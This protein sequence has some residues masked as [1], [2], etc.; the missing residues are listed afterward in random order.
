[1]RTIGWVVSMAPP[2]P[3]PGSVMNTSLAAVPEE[4]SG[5]FSE[6]AAIKVAMW[7]SLVALLVAVTWI[8][9][10]TPV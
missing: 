4:A 10:G 8:S 9:W 7:V 2:D 1:M 3:L 5:G 6:Y